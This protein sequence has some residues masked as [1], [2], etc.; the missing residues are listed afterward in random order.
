MK[1]EKSGY[2]EDWLE[3]YSTENNRIC[4][5]AQPQQLR[6]WFKRGS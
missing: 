6:L 1:P 4:G 5:V 2:A 3:Q